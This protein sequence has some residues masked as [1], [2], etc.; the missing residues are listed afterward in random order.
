MTLLIVTAI[1]AGV[2]YGAYRVIKAR[3]APT[4]LPEP[5]PG[6][7]SPTVASVQPKSTPPNVEKP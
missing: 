1:I 6:T 5:Q 2:V 4:V 3:K 7:T